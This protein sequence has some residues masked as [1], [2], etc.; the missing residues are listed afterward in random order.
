MTNRTEYTIRTNHLPLGGGS[1]MDLIYSIDPFTDEAACLSHFA[2]MGTPYFAGTQYVAV[3]TD[4]RG[5][6]WSRTVI[7]ESPFG[8]N[9]PASYMRGA[10]A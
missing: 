4:W 7:A 6:R 1:W 10:G 9:F 3:R 5:N 2:K 8:D